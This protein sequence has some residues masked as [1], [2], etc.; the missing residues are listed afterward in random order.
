MWLRYC[1]VL[2]VCWVVGARGQERPLVVCSTTQM[3]DFARELVGDRME[4]VCILGA[5]VN[6]HVYQPVPGDSRLV[7][8]SDLC[9]QNGLHLEGKNWMAEPGPGQRQQ[10]AGDLHGR[11]AAPGPEY[12][13]EI[14]QGSACLV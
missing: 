2:V 13:G 1:I 6:P 7:E 9:L 11:G 12:E 5:G 10:A 4:V 14:D 3:A 8:R